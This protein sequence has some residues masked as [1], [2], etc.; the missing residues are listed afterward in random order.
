MLSQTSAIAAPIQIT[1]QNKSVLCR[2]S[3][4]PSMQFNTNGI[5]IVTVIP[6]Y[7]CMPP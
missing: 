4:M 3:D 2:D 6:Y 5:I 7:T 1:Q